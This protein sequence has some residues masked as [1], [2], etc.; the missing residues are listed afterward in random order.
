MNYML[1]TFRNSRNVMYFLRINYTFLHENSLNLKLKM[2]YLKD[3]EGNL[4]VLKKKH[5]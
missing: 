1:F 3:W 5:S 4:E 2:K